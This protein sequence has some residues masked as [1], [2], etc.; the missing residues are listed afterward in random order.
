[1]D[2]HYHLFVTPGI[3]NQKTI[4]MLHARG[5][6]MRIQD[7]ENRIPED[8]PVFLL[9][10]Q[11]ILAPALLLRWAARLRTN[12]GDPEMAR[13]VEDHAQKMIY[14]Q[15]TKYTKL[16]DLDPDEGYMHQGNDQDFKKEIDLEDFKSLYLNE[17]VK[18]QAK[19][20]EDIGLYNK[21]RIAKSNGDPI[22]PEA[23]YFLLRYDKDPAALKALETYAKETTNANL[24]ADLYSVI[25][26]FK[27]I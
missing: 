13:M 25:T 21:Y 6:Y 23:R 11:D 27:G 17:P 22:D 8:E 15:K 1:M 4:T 14:W 26:K 7:P 9:R 16:P 19:P 10:G 3:I 20:D 24:A 12:G 18:A 5:D 2:A